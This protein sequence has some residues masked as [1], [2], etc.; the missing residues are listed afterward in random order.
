MATDPIEIL[1]RRNAEVEK[2]RNYADL[3]PEA[4]QRRIDE[5]SE[6]AREAYEA[7]LVQQ[8][9]ERA[10][11]LEKAKAAV[12]RVPVPRD[13]TE[14]EKAQ[15]YASFRAAAN[16]AYYAAT[17]TDNPTGELER[18]LT[19]AERSG[20]ELLAR[21]AYHQAIDL[22]VQSV[23]DSYLTARP[24]E[25]RIWERYTEAHQE[26]SQASSFDG[27]LQR[28]LSDRAFNDTDSSAGGSSFVV[29]AP[30]DTESS[31]GGG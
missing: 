16:D 30:P 9:E 22:G 7:A 6:R 18:L 28:S 29:A 15:I 8:K 14:A 20:D 12:F 31:G 5:V 10:A 24:S 4:R 19:Q 27:L 3:T 17:L 21:A 2:I 23:V 26:V 1:N 11:R 25:N 13:A